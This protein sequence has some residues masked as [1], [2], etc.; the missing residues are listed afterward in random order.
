[1]L[2]ATSIRHIDFDV[3]VGIG[4]LES[5]DCACQRHRLSRIEHCERMVQENS[6]IEKLYGAHGKELCCG[7]R[8]RAIN[9]RSGGIKAALKAQFR[10][11]RMQW[12]PA[13]EGV[14]VEPLASQS[15]R[16]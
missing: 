7:L 15:A 3:C 10:L 9:L 1:M 11:W 8:R 4:P 5:G 2:R 6:N 16:Q 12:K 13:A 14:A